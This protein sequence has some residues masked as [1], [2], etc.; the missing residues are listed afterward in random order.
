M[1]AKKPA[2]A[3]EL[4]KALFIQG[5]KYSIISQQVDVSQA[6]IRAWASRGKWHQL[7]TKAQQVPLQALERGFLVETRNSLQAMGDKIREQLSQE[8]ADQVGLLAKQPARSAGDL[9]TVKGVQGR[10]S[11]VK[12]IAETAALVHDWGSQGN[13]GLVLIGDLSQ[14]PAGGSGA[15]L[16]DVA[17]RSQSSGGA[18][19]NR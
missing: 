7:A 14:E 11:V 17:A 18:D 19:H 2:E 4:A 12:T 16:V 10:A 13:A 15:P 6:L 1:A 9:A 5:V 3:K 8:L